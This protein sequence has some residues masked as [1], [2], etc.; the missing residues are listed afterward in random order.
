MHGG[1]ALKLHLD[2][3]SKPMLKYLLLYQS[4]S[5]SIQQLVHKKIDDEKIMINIRAVELV[6]NYKEEKDS[7]ILNYEGVKIIK[8]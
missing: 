1:L 7:F 5:F 6:L 8:E 4:N 2:F 3:V